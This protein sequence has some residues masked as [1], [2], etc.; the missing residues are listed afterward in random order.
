LLNTEP[1]DLLQESGG[2]FISRLQLVTP[3]AW[4]NPTPCPAWTVRT[5]IAHIVNGF[6]MIPALLEGHILTPP[7]ETTTTSAKTSLNQRKQAL[8]RA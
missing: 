1:A 5:V 3:D 7:N 6:H 2:Y 8:K 4:A